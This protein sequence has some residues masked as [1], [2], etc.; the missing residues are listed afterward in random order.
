MSRSKQKLYCAFVDFQKAFDTVWRVGLWQKL[1]NSHVRGKC[2]TVIYNMYQG[3]TS[4]VSV[5]GKISPFF[6]QYS[7]GVRQGENLSPFL[8]SNYLND[9]EQYLRTNNVAG[10]DC[11]LQTDELFMYFKLFVLL[12]AD[13]TVIFADSANN[14]QHVLNIFE[15]YCTVWRL[16]VIIDKTKI[17]IFGRGKHKNLVFHFGSNPIEIVNIFKYLG[18][19]FTRGGSF[20][21]TIKHNTDQAKK[22]MF[23]LLR[24]INPLNLSIDLQ[25][26]LFDKMNLSY[27]TAVKCGD[28][29]T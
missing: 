7:M 14:L 13:D 17:M 12:Y 1:S 6:F 27:Y 8:F 16:T 26:D 23:L 24:K 19:I 9:L 15:N 10:I 2:F 18:V 28:S 29:A 25:I 22:A 11:T 5:N 20:S 21:K 3:I 4:C